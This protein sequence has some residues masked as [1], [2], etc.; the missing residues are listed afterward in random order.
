MRTE[1][2]NDHLR[3]E[4]V[5][6]LI[7][8]RSETC[9]ESERRAFDIWIEDP[10]HRRVYQAVQT[11]WQGMA[12]FKSQSFSARDRALSYRPPLWRTHPTALAT[13]ALL[14]V[15]VLVSGYRPNGWL[16]TWES[17]ATA[18]GAHENLVLADGS[19]I[20][21]NSDSEL[22]VHFNR[23]RRRVELTRGEAFFNVA[24]DAER[25]FEVR[26]SNGT[27]RDVGTAFDVYL[28]PERVQVAVQEGEVEIAVRDRRVLAAGQHIV[29]T[30]NGEWASAAN[31]DVDELTAWRRGLLVFHARRLEDVL[32]EIA[33]HHDVAISIQDDALRDLRVSGTFR[34][35]RLDAV[36]DAIGT[37]LPVAVQYDGSRA[38]RLTSAVANL[39]KT[40]H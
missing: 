31:G 9:T 39:K 32:A 26:A 1:S 37:T 35:G 24:H 15:T 10:D 4:A 22:R 16:G 28:A 38:I 14:L 30:R 21:L 25:P 7:R 12:S 33:R 20:E 3:N 2:L 19:R 27:I 8:L 18:K 29:Y 17:H 23:W 5:H 6:W 34:T 13:A 40:S 11:Q 36:L